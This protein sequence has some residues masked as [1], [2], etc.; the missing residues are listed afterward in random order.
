[1]DRRFASEL[2][3]PPYGFYSYST[4]P[5]FRLTE[6][7][8]D[9][10]KLLGGSVDEIK[11]KELADFLASPEKEDTVTVLQSQLERTGE[12]EK[13]MTFVRQD[14]TSVYVLN[15]GKIEEDR[16]GNEYV[17]NIFVC[18]ENTGHLV[19]HLRDVVEAYQTRLSQTET[20]INLL[21]TCAEQD[22]LTKIFNAG[23]TRRLAEEYI[24]APKSRCAMFII[25]VDDF[26]RVNDRYGHMVG[27]DVM[28]CAAKAIKTLIRSN[29]IV[30]RIGGDE[31]LVL[32]KDV[33]DI[34]IV[35]LRCSQILEAFNEMQFDRM[36][37]ERMSCSVGAAVSGSHKLCYDEMFLCADKAM[38]RAKNLG[39]NKYI[40]KECN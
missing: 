19:E 25:D 20:K 38:Y 32:M 22:S 26:K 11:G 33:S 31:F 16:F 24:Y 14:G 30:G 12:T 6:D 13:L 23:T 28:I 3:S 1:M 18:A 27:D 15:R 35:S 29:D 4:E 40:V 21:Q 36:K 9:L 39:G 37:N 7:C 8:G 17:R 34:N 5:G 10:A 2:I